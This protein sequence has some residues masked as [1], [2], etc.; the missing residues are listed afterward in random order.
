MTRRVRYLFVLLCCVLALG[1]RAAVVFA[2]DFERN[3]L[4]EDWRMV[5]TDTVGKNVAWEARAEG[6]HCLRLTD[7]RI[8]TPLFTVKPGQY[9]RLTVSVT[10][11]GRP[12]WS[13]FFRDSYGYYLSGDH[14]GGLDATAAWT[15]QRVIFSTKFPGVSACLLLTSGGPET[16]RV[17]DLRLETITPADAD[18]ETAALAKTMPAILPPAAQDAET[19]LPHIRAKLRKGGALRAVVLG[20]SIGNDLS[21]SPLDVLLQRAYPKASVEL[22]FTGRGSTGYDIFRRS[23]DYTV[24]KY[25]PDLVVL[26]AITNRRDSDLTDNLQ[27][28]ID[29]IRHDLPETDILLVTPHVD[30]FSPNQL[31]GSAQRETLR[32]LATKNRLALV[33]LLAAWQ[34]YLKS[35]EKPQEWLLRDVVH[36]NERGR[37]VTATAV[38][39][40]LLPDP[41]KE[42]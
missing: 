39:A 19:L 28:I 1:V 34:A 42:Q 2:T 12:M 30:E 31:P 25:K 36:M 35:V 10:G 21:N 37:L 14:Y 15:T 27:S 4:D 18:A 13:V 3:P 11:D 26:L 32:A 5:W 33:D 17:D 29:E 9:Y 16:L 22:R 40:W 23:V 7:G 20:D 41:P 8:F 38:A 6:G 24:V